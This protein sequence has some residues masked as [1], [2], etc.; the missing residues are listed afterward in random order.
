M[1]ENFPGAEDDRRQ[2]VLGDGDRQAGFLPQERVK[3]AQQGDT[4]GGI[5]T[6]DYVAL[7]ER[8]SV[9]EAIREV[10]AVG[11][12]VMVSYI[13]VTD[14]H[15]RLRGVVSLRQLILAAPDQPLR[16]I[17]TRDVWKV[18]VETDQEEVARL[19]AHY[20]ILAIP[21]VD[22]QNKLVGVVTVDDLLDHL[23][24]E[25]WRDQRVGGPR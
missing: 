12:K 21:V 8:L 4:A 10:R 3:A 18:H 9:E 19:V 13:Y 20:N 24:P 11:D 17:M 14:D 25:G 2:G 16:D 5:M 7:N 1:V 22:E 23:L 15:D 6:T